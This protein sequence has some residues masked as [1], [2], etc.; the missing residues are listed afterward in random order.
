LGGG[1]AGEEGH[2]TALRE[3]AEND[4]RRGNTGGDFG[5]NEGVEV[6]LGFKDTRLVLACLE[7]VEAKLLRCFSIHPTSN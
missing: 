6:L 3:A 2:G 1:D 4:A 7:I 5:G